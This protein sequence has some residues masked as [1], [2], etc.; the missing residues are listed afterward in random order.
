[1]EKPP[2]ESRPFRSD[3]QLFDWDY[4]AGGRIQL[5]VS[6]LDEDLRLATDG[7]RGCL[8]GEAQGVLLHGKLQLVDG[9]VPLWATLIEGPGAKFADA[10]F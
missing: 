8:I 10:I 9:Q 5:A 3:V 6:P 4:G 2:C 7:C 1:M